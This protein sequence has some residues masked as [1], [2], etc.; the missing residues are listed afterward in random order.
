MKSSNQFKDLS[1]A[2]LQKRLLEFKKEL[3][4]LNTQV[5]AGANTANSAKIRVT[6]KN[7]AR[8]LTILQEKGVGYN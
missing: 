5:A 3:L 4:K 7:I 2:D 8:A 6:K 1:V